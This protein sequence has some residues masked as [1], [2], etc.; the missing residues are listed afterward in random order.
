MMLRRIFAGVAAGAIANSIQMV[1]CLLDARVVTLSLYISHWI[2]VLLFHVA[3]ATLFA[4]VSDNR[5]WSA[6]VFWVPVTSVA[7]R[8]LDR[9]FGMWGAVAGA[10][11]A[12]VLGA[13]WIRFFPRRGAPFL[14]AAAGAVV[15]AM[16]PY[17][18]EVA[19]TSRVGS[20]SLLMLAGL[21]F[22]VAALAASFLGRAEAPLVPSM[23]WS[24]RRFVGF[25]CVA[26]L[27]ILF[28]KPTTIPPPLSTEPSDKSTAILIV[29]D[30]VRADHLELYGY[31]RETMPALTRFAR[32][33]A[34]V[35]ERAISNAPSSLP[36]HASLFTGLYPVRH[37]A[38]KPFAKDPNPPEYA[39][40][41]H[42]SIPTLATILAKANYWTVGI[43]ANSGP[44]A[45]FF[46]LD[47]GFHVYHAEPSPRRAFVAFSP[48][49]IEEISNLWL[50]RIALA[51]SAVFPSTR[52]YLL[53]VP[54][55]RA[56]EITDE[57]IRAVELAGERPLFLFVNYMDAHS[58]YFPPADFMDRFPGRS[59]S[60]MTSGF[61][62]RWWHAVV[63]GDVEISDEE[64]R[65]YSSLYD[66]ELSYL[67]T[68]LDRF[69]QWLRQRPDWDE[70]LIVITS[71]HGEA[72]GD[73]GG[74]EHSNSLYDEITHV[75]LVVKP[76]THT[77]GAPAAGSVLSGLIES[78]DIFAL[79]LEHAGLR[80]PRGVDGSSWGAGRTHSFGW[81]YPSPSLRDPQELRSV[82]T[83]GWKLVESSSGKIELYHIDSDPAEALDLSV[84]ENKIG[85]RLTKTLNEKRH[86]V[87]RPT[88]PTPELSE[89]LTDQLRAL[90][91]AK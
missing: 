2:F 7:A 60:L 85:F 46:G 79:I 16:L 76:G 38:H 77:P 65:H 30:T 52:D 68:E 53:G 21:L 81:L 34:V 15:G 90:G 69:L 78:V 54:Y 9:L 26:L 23:G 62:Q 14:S 56:A 3:A 83:G 13:L 64:R 27:P 84:A 18:H 37:G 39:Y 72:L 75:P 6:V 59:S 87:D 10:V 70:L 8:E 73:H 36:S 41:L 49:G 11:G 40:R 17:M 22:A 20:V 86:K 47:Q 63:N 1:I 50:E 58:P 35:A 25:S 42:P 71:D 80:V 32:E 61:D 19:Y 91:Y 12:I 51:F 82:Q 57:A 89:D 24:L 74:L 29:L 67:D 48:W 43:S 45:P 31:E 44:L 55:K 4:K 66:A 5:L 28:A 88:T 33:N